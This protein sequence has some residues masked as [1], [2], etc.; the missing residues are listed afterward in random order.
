[1]TIDEE[2]ALKHL[3]KLAHKRDAK[4]QYQLASLYIQGKLVNKDMARGLI[5]LA[6]SAE[7]GYEDARTLLS[8]MGGCTS[9]VSNNLIDFEAELTVLYEST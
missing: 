6:L 1:M 9:L 7:Q 5:F 2:T 8:R 4:A 3:R